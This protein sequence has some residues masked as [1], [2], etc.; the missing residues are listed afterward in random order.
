[1]YSNPHLLP[2]SHKDNMQDMARRGRV[3]IHLGALNPKAKL[4]PGAVR[5]IRKDPR[6]NVA[7]GAD[8]GVSNVAI[9]LIKRRINW[10]HLKD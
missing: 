7:I 10:A 4:T 2:G 1:M 9:S 6:T 8:Y 3:G 5:A